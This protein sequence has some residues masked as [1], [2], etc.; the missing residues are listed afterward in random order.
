MYCSSSRSIGLCTSGDMYLRNQGV[1]I[2]YMPPKHTMRAPSKQLRWRKTRI[3]DWRKAAGL[4]QQQVADQLTERGFELDRVS[5]TRIE[6]G[7]QMVSAE[8]LEALSDIL[9]TDI[10]SLLNYTPEEAK[11]L[12]EFR[13]LNPADQEMVLEMAKVARGRK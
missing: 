3:E 13:K 9:K 1:H 8:V 6:N 5:V 10:D 2:V 11:R 7:K 12:R 4:T